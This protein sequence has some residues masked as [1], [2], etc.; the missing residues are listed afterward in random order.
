MTMRINNLTA[1]HL[2]RKNM[3][4]ICD[5]LL[6]DAKRVPAHHSAGLKNQAL[7]AA[8][9]S[10]TAVV[11]IGKQTGLWHV[12]AS[13]YISLIPD[14]NLMRSGSSNLASSFSSGKVLL[15][16]PAS[17]MEITPQYLDNLVAYLV[18]SRGI[19]RD[20]IITIRVPKQMLQL[21]KETI[22]HTLVR[23]N[24]NRKLDILYLAGDDPK[25][26]DSKFIWNTYQL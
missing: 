11:P 19:D 21:A 7:I 1:A 6:R 15:I 25:G 2:R 18:N 20:K 24:T 3:R 26:L 17:T 12:G 23:L 8:L 13:S 22:T 16:P 9:F 4:N 14:W 5:M 10:C